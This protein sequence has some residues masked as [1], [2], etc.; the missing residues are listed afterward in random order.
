LGPP[1]QRDGQGEPGDR[2]DRAGGEGGLVALACLVWFH[3]NASRFGFNP[4]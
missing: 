2:D 4:D 1:K 3:T